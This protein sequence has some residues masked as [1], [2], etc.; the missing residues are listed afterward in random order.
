[1]ICVDEW[2]RSHVGMAVDI[3]HESVI[4]RRILNN[5]RAKSPLYQVCEGI[6]LS[7]SRKGL[8][9]HIYATW[10]DVKESNTH[11]AFSCTTR[12]GIFS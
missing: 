10:L 6:F 1:M 3:E 8:R 9:W 12:Y 2:K 11:S 5:R 7:F 4:H